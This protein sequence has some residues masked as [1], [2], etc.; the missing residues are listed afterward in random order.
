MRSQKKAKQADL[1]IRSSL[2]RELGLDAGTRVSVREIMR[3][4]D[5]LREN[6][7][8]QT[9][10]EVANSENE[11][12]KTSGAQLD[13]GLIQK[14]ME[15]NAQKKEPKT[16]KGAEG[17]FTRRTSIDEDTGLP[18]I[19]FFEG[20]RELTTDELYFPTIQEI[21][22]ERIEQILAPGPIEPEE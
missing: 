9:F 10:L 21:R 20:K 5:G 6:F 7:V 12:N 13:M 18:Q 11:I 14:A 4:L 16:G 8:D 15:M 3:R 19:R 17:P 22:E 2:W 1:V